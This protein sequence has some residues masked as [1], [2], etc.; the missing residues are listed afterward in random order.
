MR[1]V[2]L[3]AG[4]ML[5]A[6]IGGGAAAQ[7]KAEPRIDL[8]AIGTLEIPPETATIRYSVRGEGATADA[9]TKA[10]VA[11]KQA[12]EDALASFRDLKLDLR[13]G[14]MRIQE[15]RS[16]D[17]QRNS[18]MPRLSTGACA[19]Q[20][21][22]AEI[23]VTVKLSPVARAGTLTGLIAQAGGSDV[24]LSGFG[25]IDPAAAR[26]QAMA[27]AIANGKIQ[28]EA[29]AS[30]SGA[31]LGPLLRVSDADMRDGIIAEDL[32]ILPRVSTADGVRSYASVPVAIT[33]DKVTITA[34]L[35][36]SYEIVR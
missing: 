21:Y 11:R 14:Q 5:G 1:C 4:V 7:E 17:C 31:K 29:I 9:A 15:V 16:G 35:N 10:L 3:G 19:V 22:I 23:G 33:P 8:V 25:L 18:M 13:T 6:F 12:V 2:M 36:L 30:A 26:R 32:G 28:A 20:G 24:N 34:R 27:M